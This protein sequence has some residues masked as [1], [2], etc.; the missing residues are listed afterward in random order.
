MFIAQELSS[1]SALPQWPGSPQCL[2]NRS[3]DYD[4]WVPRGV[5]LG[6]MNLIPSFRIGALAPEGVTWGLPASLWLRLTDAEN[7]AQESVTSLTKKWFL[8]SETTRLLLGPVPRG[9]APTVLARSLRRGTPQHRPL[10]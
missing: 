6:D 4:P 2:G 5:P 3:E 9:P 8:L 10:G 7:W 1:Y